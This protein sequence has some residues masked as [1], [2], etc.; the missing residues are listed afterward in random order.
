MDILELYGSVPVV[1]YGSG[2]SGVKKMG[3]EMLGE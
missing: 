1:L 3:R 2:A